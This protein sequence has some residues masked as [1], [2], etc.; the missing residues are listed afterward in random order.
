MPIVKNPLTVSCFHCYKNLLVKFVPP[1]KEYSK[2]NNWGYWT[3]KKE[4]EEKYICDKCLRILY[5]KNKWVFSEEVKSLKKRQML[6][7]YIYDRV[8]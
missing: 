3:E 6:R 8:I 7:N 1:H 5:K 2:K 4:N